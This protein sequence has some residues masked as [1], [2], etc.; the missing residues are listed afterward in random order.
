MQSG[1]GAGGIYINQCS[2]LHAEMLLAIAKDGDCLN[3]DAR[4]MQAGYN[5]MIGSRNF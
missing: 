4:I 2:E 3:E 1:I 5:G